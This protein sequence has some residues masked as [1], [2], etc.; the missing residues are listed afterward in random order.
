MHSLRTDAPWGLGR[1]SSKT[2]LV[3]QNAVALAFSYEYDSTAGSGATVF[4]IGTW[5][6]LIRSPS[7]NSRVLDT[8]VFTNH[9]SQ[10]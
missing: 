4:V 10:Y 9:V 1:I 3:N 2:K 7:F 5:N 6:G 8:G